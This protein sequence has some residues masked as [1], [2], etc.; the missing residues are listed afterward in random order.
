MGIDETGPTKTPSSDCIR[1]I[2]RRQGDLSD[3]LTRFAVQLQKVQKIKPCT[4][5][6]AVL[7]KGFVRCKADVYH[8]SMW[9]FRRLKRTIEAHL[10]EELLKHIQA[11]VDLNVRVL[12]RVDFIQHWCYPLQC[13]RNAHLVTRQLV[14]EL[15]HLAKEH[16]FDFKSNLIKACLEPAEISER[17]FKNFV[18]GCDSPEEWDDV[19]K[20]FEKLLQL[21]LEV[22]L[23]AVTDGEIFMRGDGE[24]W[25]V[26]EPKK[27]ACTSILY[28]SLVNVLS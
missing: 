21:H 17:E 1:M 13:I 12:Y 28:L 7:L 14:L 5:G 18:T 25:R 8:E 9:T 4:H 3:S 23:H 27:C 2:A 11:T 16:G 22:S 6:Q 15:E 24:R 10:P 26:T 19:S 20:I